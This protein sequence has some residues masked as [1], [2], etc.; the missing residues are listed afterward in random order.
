[1]QTKKGGREVQMA[2]KI[3]YVLN[4]RH[5]SSHQEH[6]I[7]DILIHYYCIHTRCI[8]TIQSYADYNTE[9]ANSD[10][11]SSLGSGRV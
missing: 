2:C 1:M 10:F 7:Q 11:Q 3:A 4:G 9:Q 5:L 8:Q 6:L